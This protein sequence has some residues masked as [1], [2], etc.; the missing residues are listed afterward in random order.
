[1]GTLGLAVGGAKDLKPVKRGRKPLLEGGSC[2]RTMSA[3]R[4]PTRE[5]KRE[6]NTSQLPR[7]L[8]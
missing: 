6:R 4:V 8:C 7:L 2:N 1:M 5:P 3:W